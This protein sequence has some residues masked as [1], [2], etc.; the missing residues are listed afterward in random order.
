MFVWIF[1]ALAAVFLVASLLQF[2]EV[3]IPFHNAYLW[4]SRETRATMELRP[5][6]HQ[7]ALALAICA[8]TFLCIAMECVFLTIWLWALVALLAV[9]L[10]V[11]AILV[12]R[13]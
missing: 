2:L 6:F 3:G 12:E 4:A 5:Y 10:L 9:A 13:K 1:A 8:A 7:A 11:F